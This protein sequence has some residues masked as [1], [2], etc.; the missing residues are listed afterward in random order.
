MRF[1]VD[2][3]ELAVVLALDTEPPGVDLTQDGLGDACLNAAVEGMRASHRARSS[4]DGP[5]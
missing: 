5:A 4:P 3:G 1:T 2:V